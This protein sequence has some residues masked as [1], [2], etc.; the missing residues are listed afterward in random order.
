MYK[1]IALSLIYDL[2]LVFIQELQGTDSC[3][4]GGQ[5]VLNT[6]FLSLGFSHV[7][8]EVWSVRQP[9]S[10]LD[11]YFFHSTFM[12]QR[13]CGIGRLCCLT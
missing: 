1:D 11:R 5:R 10:Q 7:L 9:L 6:S 13:H 3:L 8:G 2:Y 4:K 12:G